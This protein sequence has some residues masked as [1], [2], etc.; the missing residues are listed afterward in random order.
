MAD[1]KKDERERE[2]ELEN[3]ETNQ[4][5][6]SGESKSAEGKSGEG[7]EKKSEKTFT[8]EQVTKMMTREKNQGRNSVYKEL[9]IN[10]DD[11]KTVELF[12]QFIADQKTDEQ[13]AAEAKAENEAKIVEAENRAKVA[14]A[15]AEAMMLGVKTQFV[16]DIVTLALS[17][18]TDDTDLKTVIGELKTKYT[19]MFG[20][21]DKDDKNDKGKKGTGSSFKASNEKKSDEKSYGARLAA[22]RKPS[23]QKKSYWGK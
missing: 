14:E 17:K 11:K 2:E 13:K 5:K 7:N 23:S 15:K 10:P 20:T 12:K 4:S 18:L 9:G 3:K 19:A 21:D 6:E 1:E 8:Q 22:Q 16:D